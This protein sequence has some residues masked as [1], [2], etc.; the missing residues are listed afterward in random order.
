MELK[1]ALRIFAHPIF[2]VLLLWM[3]LHSLDLLGL[4]L[5]Q[6]YNIPGLVS[7]IHPE[8]SGNAS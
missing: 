8:P 7:F 1:G 6:K 2:I 4:Y 3:I 5:A